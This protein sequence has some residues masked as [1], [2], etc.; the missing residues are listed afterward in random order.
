MS[1]TAWRPTSRVPSASANG[2]HGGD[3]IVYSIDPFPLP[4]GCF[5]GDYIELVTKYYAEAESNPAFLHDPS[6][7][8]ATISP[9][10]SWSATTGWPTRGRPCQARQDGHLPGV[11]LRR[12]RVRRGWRRLLPGF[13][14]P[15]TVG[16]L[17]E[18]QVED[19]ASREVQRDG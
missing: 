14:V 6:N 19:H 13:R 5:I 18:L 9:R 11:R 4:A 2:G 16:W 8:R 17:G 3:C 1:L 15:A 7:V 12:S 10:I